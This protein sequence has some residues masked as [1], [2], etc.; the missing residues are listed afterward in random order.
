M[1][2]NLVWGVEGRG[3]SLAEAVE[4]VNRDPGS[5]SVWNVV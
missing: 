1:V 3:K 5:F 4:T 2:K